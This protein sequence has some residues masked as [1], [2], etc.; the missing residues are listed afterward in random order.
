MKSAFTFKVWRGSLRNRLLMSFLLLSLIPLLL[1]SIVA[2]RTIVVGAQEAVVR[3]MTALAH[4]AANAVNVYMSDRVGDQL[5]WSRMNIIMEAL[6]IAEAREP[7]QETLMDLVKLSSSYEAVMLLDTRGNCVVSSSPLLAHKNLASDPLF[8]NAMKGNIYINDMYSDSRIAEMR[9][10]SGGWTVGISTP[11]KIGKEISGVLCT[12]LNWSVIEAILKETQVG[13][14][15]YVWMVNQN[16]QLIVHPSRNLYLEPLDGPKVQLPDLVDAMKKGENYHKYWFRNAKTDK[17]DHKLVGLAY[18]KGFGSFTGIGWKF[19]AGADMDEVLGFIPRIF[20]NVVIAALFAA[21]LVVGLSYFFARGIAMPIAAIAKEISKVGAG[22]LTVELPALNRNDEVASLANAFSLMISNLREQAKQMLKGVSVLTKT[23]EGISIAVSRLGETALES[24]NAVKK[25][26]ETV[27]EV[28]QEVRLSSDKVRSVADQAGAITRSGVAAAE[29]TALNMEFIKQQMHHIRASVDAL[30]ARSREI[31]QI[32]LSVR[33]IADQS[34][35]LA[36]NASIEAAQAGEHGRGFAVVAHEIK[37]LANGSKK[38]TAN[39]QLFLKEIG[40]S[41][42]SVID[43]TEA[44]DKAVSA[45]VEQAE[46]AGKSVRSLSH[47]L[48]ASSGNVTAIEA[49]S[50]QQV[51]GLEEISSSITGIESAVKQSAESARQLEEAVA[52]LHGLG[53]QLSTLASRFK[54]D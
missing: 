43:A 37:N 42:D 6:E 53:S 31:E 36:V 17:L 28:Q 35:L 2:Y 15:G 47:S 30:G 19:G 12:F 13:S 45:G 34:N 29:Q 48:S 51:I 22:D 1:A 33:D 4:S 7:A 39:V 52:E 24:S 11:V 20:R 40:K 9:T 18:P 27:D 25:A 41:I 46:L 50:N 3:E 44:A 14:T 49:S 10:E 23:G 32:V 8:V 21:V 54:V 5:V 26:T 38:S 16:H